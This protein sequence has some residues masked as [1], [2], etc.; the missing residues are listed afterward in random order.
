MIE[1]LW[2]F[3][4]FCINVLVKRLINNFNYVDSFIRK[5]LSHQ[6]AFPQRF[7]CVVKFLESH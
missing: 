5:A 4:V 3:D 1:L 7:H 2:T 6:I